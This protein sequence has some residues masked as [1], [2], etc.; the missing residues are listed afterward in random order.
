[1]IFFESLNFD[2]KEG[3]LLLSAIAILTTS[4][5]MHNGYLLNGSSM[6]PFEIVDILKED[7]DKME[8]EK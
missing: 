3:K 5:F 6:T 2:T 7:S 8:D 1:M 4:K